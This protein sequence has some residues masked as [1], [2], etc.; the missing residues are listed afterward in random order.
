MF[1]ASMNTKNKIM[2]EKSEYLHFKKLDKRIG[3]FVAYI[4]YLVDIKNA[5]HE[6]KENKIISQ[7]KLFGRLGL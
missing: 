6:I 7:E 3:D 4:D 5:R 1:V 2:I